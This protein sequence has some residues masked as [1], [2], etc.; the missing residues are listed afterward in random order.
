MGL[1]R[2][3]REKGDYHKAGEIYEEFIGH[4]KNSPFITIMYLNAGKAYYFAGEKNNA[5]RNF[6]IIISRY[7]DSEEKKEAIYY[8]EL[9]QSNTAGT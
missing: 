1:P 6:N 2:Y 7:G 8:T 4:Y 3:I 9:L 5:L